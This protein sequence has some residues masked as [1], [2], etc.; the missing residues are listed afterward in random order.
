MNKD[1]I[2]NLLTKIC[3]D[4][5]I[6]DGIFSFENN[7]HVEVLKEHLL[8]YNISNKKT[9]DILNN[10]LEGK[11]PERQA[12]NKDGLLVTFPTPEYKQRA[13]Q[14]GT[15]FE[16][17][18]KKSQTGVF[19]TTPQ[20]A[21]PAPEISKEQ[22]AKIAPS[23]FAP[24]PV[25]Q[26]LEKSIQPN[27]KDTRTAQEKK[28]DADAIEKILSDAPAS[29]DITSKYPNVESIV[30]SLKEA[31][32]NNFYEKNGKWY[33]SDGDYVGFKWYCDDTGKIFVSK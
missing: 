23:E 14:R 2:D 27:S 25:Q 1:F 12:Y 20:P 15:H 8:N 11:Y 31:I 10:I 30:Y 22:P 28:I 29:I 6:T 26:D 33:T 17:N 32:S 16:Q 4:D 19:Q 13:I 9:L 18:P 24:L 5:R 21:T 3:L 7:N